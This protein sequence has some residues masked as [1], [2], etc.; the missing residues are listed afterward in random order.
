MR[1]GSDCELLLH[2]Y[3]D[4]WHCSSFG[5]A[6]S[7]CEFFIVLGD[8][9]LA[10]F[11]AN[12]CK[13]FIKSLDMHPLCR[14]LVNHLKAHESYNLIVLEQLLTITT[15]RAWGLACACSSL[16]TCLWCAGNYAQCPLLLSL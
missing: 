11:T 8:Q 12:V 7:V 2:L 10:V 13:R 6:P 15:V 1:A 4:T 16:M 5:S 14:Y 9:G 3:C